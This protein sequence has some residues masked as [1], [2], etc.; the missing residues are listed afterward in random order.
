MDI[1]KTE[2]STQ[3]APFSATVKREESLVIFKMQGDLDVNGAPALRNVFIANIDDKDSF[4]AC[5]MS[6]VSYINSAGLGVFVGIHKHTKDREGQLM[7]LT[8]QKTVKRVFKIAS[9]DLHIMFIDSLDEARRIASGETRAED[10][11]GD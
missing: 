8:P 1:M 10:Q 9:L 6:D 7:I 2:K 5:D 4:I 11:S 3:R